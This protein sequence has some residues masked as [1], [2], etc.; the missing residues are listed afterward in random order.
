MA[1]RPGRRVAIVAGLRTPFVK[2]GTAFK[3]LSALELG[4]QV[5]SE[6][7]QRAEIPPA[8]IDQLVFGTVIPSVQLSNIAR[9]VGLASGLPRSLDA[10]SVTRACA[11]S[12][13][14]FTSAA[15]SIALGE[16]DLA[17]AG[18]AEALSDVPISYSRPVAQ[19]VVQASKGRS[20][21][22]KLQAF[23]EVSAR[24]L[25]PVPPAIAE[26]S[27]GLSMGESAE[28]MAKENG[29]SREAQDAWAHRSHFLA[30]QAWEAGKFAKEVMRVLTGR[31]FDV[32]VGEDNIVRK[33]SKLESYARLK[34]V[35]DRKYG[36]ITAG[37]SSP[38]TDGAAALVVCSEERARELGLK[39]L[40]FLRAYAYAAVD[41]AWQ[42]LQ[43]PA[44]SAP[45]ALKRAGMKLSDI[46]LV[47]IHEAFSA[48]VLSNLQAWASKKFADQ[49]LGGAEP[50]GEVPEEKLNPRG[51]S[52]ALGHPFGGT[53]ARLIHQ[54]LRELE[55][56]GKNTALVSV[57]A[58]GGLGAAVILERT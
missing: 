45:K 9:E 36:S 28:K 10:Y 38:L 33:D 53:G 22:E 27:T 18:G 47:E 43:A 3:D 29:I 46:D 34:P 42:L 52:I 50:I 21:M 58:A 48:Q 1:S 8:A 14:A 6:L 5:V 25:L 4:K 11:T 23:H 37:N 26:Y 44:F 40:G 41:P 2:S 32:A 51:G 39:P 19:A 57:C 13:Q 54:A 17:I 30:A 56:K 15:D 12:I 49:Y 24:D 20:L 55:E 31:N 16:A 7:V 35:F